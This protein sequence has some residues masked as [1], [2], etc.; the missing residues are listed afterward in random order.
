MSTYWEED[1]EPIGEQAARIVTDLLTLANDDEARRLLGIDATLEDELDVMF[2]DDP[3]AWIASEIANAIRL[4]DDESEGVSLSSVVALLRL[5]RIL[6][7]GALDEAELQ[8]AVRQALEDEGETE[9]D[10]R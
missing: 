2:L 8:D 1:Q 7:G 6:R 5:Y 4:R 9:D 10:S 3:L